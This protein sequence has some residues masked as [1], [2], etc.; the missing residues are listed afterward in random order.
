MAKL[1]VSAIALG[2]LFISA[3][4]SNAQEG[5][6]SVRVAGGLAAATSNPGTSSTSTTNVGSSYALDVDVNR[7]IAQ[8]VDVQLGVDLFRAPVK[9]IT[10]GQTTKTDGFQFSSL[11]V[12]LIFDVVRVPA[13]N[14]YVGPVIGARSSDSATAMTPLSG[15]RISIP[16][17]AGVGFQGGIRLPG[18][19]SRRTYAFDAKFKWLHFRE[20]TSNGSKLAD[21]ILV[22]FGVLH[23]F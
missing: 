11:S 3:S 17:S 8:G 12:G 7:A 6:W 9:V 21:P 19:I 13:S 2:L 16:G 23:R 1:L 22:T 10:Q 14:I 15:E 18:F 20:K 5:P 4:V